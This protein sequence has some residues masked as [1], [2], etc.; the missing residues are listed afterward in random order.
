MFQWL[1]LFG[2]QF[3]CIFW[4]EFFCSNQQ[5]LNVFP[6][7]RD[8]F[9][10]WKKAKIKNKHF[11]NHS[12]YNEQILIIIIVDSFYNLT[13][14]YKLGIILHRRKWNETNGKKIYTFII[15]IRSFSNRLNIKILNIITT[16]AAT[17]N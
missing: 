1:I 2:R 16:I 8:I 12:V 4:C 14:M 3:S 11:S 6:E 10:F 9:I 13:L 15:I 17:T 5:Q 7:K